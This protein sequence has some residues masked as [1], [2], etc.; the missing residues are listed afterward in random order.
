MI[1]QGLVMLMWKV[2]M[3]WT[4]SRNVLG[5]SVGKPVGKESFRR[6]ERQKVNVI[7]DG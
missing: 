3:G 6:E 7:R 5:I 2:I 1:G 4:S